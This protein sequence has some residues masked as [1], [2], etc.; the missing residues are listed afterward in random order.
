MTASGTF[1][2]VLSG[3]GYGTIG[4]LLGVPVGFVINVTRHAG[5]R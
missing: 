4:L 5:R 1:G 2:A 3:T